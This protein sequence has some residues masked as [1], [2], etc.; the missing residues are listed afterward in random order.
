MNLNRRRFVSGALAA[1]LGVAGVSGAGAAADVTFTYDGE[2]LTLPS[3]SDATV[4]GEA[5]YGEGVRLTV[6]IRSSGSSPFIKQTTA[7]I[8][9]DGTFAATFDTSD[10]EVGTEFTATALW[11]SIEQAE[12]T[13]RVTPLDPDLS[14]DVEGET[15]ALAPATEQSVTG[16]SALAEG[17]MVT[18]VL[19]SNRG[20]VFIKQAEPTVDA[21]GGF[22]AAF[23]MS[24]LEAGTLFLVEAH[25]D[26]TRDAFAIGEVVAED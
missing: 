4:T 21:D 5:G 11:N 22:A 13:G 14:L 9:G 1:T 18:L 2:A 26:G 17:Q 8:D 23:D 7:R 12:A 15:L 19:R 16:D 6:R 20:A 25:Y 10:I 3:A 24:D